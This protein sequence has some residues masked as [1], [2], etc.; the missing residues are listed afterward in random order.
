MQDKLELGDLEID[1]FKMMHIDRSFL[2][3]MMEH[4]KQDYFESMVLG[5]IFT[6]YQQFFKKFSKYPPR[7][8]VENILTKKGIEKEKLDAF[9]TP[10][11]TVDEDLIAP[12]TKEYITDEVTKFAKRARM[13][14]AINQS[15][16]LLE[17]DSFDEIISIMKDAVVFNLDVNVGVDLYDVDSRYLALKESLENKTPTG[18][19][20]IDKILGGGW[21]RK[22]L[23]CVMGPPGFGKSIFLPNFG[24]KAMLNGLNVV[25]Y[26]MEMSEER[27]GMRYDAIA[28]G[29][30]IN[31]L[32]NKPDEIKSKYDAFKKITK[33]RLK[34]KEFPTGLASVMDIES[35]LENLKLHDDFVPDLIITD[36]GDIMRSVHKVSN[37]YEEQGWIFRELRGLGVKRNSIMLTATQ[38]NRD[39]LTQDGSSKDVVSMA[40]TA[41]S[42]EKNRI[43]DVLFTISQS[44]QEKDSG[45]INLFSAKNRNGQSNVYAKFIINYMNMQIKEPLLGGNNSSENDD[46]GDDD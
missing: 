17:N 22:E 30:I 18:Y 10:I 23:Y 8:I 15:I 28:S 14:D 32:A 13:V 20:Q 27:L 46:S 40:N 37:L 44:R 42:M 12:G 39:S 7:Q 36:Y 34:L 24:I 43:I 38:A 19:A 41:D 33:A 9:L 3:L 16:D 5:K 26:S 1:I 2:V 4:L 31:E 45:Q 25:H 6:V 29:I 35:H 21:A 11:Y